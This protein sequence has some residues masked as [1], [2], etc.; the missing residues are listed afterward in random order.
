MVSL[1]DAIRN[2]R[3][4]QLTA[5]LEIKRRD[6]ELA[7]FRMAQPFA[8]LADGYRSAITDFLGEG[9]KATRVAKAGKRAVAARDGLGVEETV[10]RL[11]ILDARR[12]ELEAK[13]DGAEAAQKTLNPVAH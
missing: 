13:L 12:R 6:F 9:R 3:T 5:I 10:K 8:I 1:Q 2:F 11:D 7:Q 4:A